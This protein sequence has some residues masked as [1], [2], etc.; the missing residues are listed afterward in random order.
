MTPWHCGSNWRCGQMKDDRGVVNFPSGAPVRNNGN[1][2]GGDGTNE[3]LARLEER[4]NHLAT[5]SQL[6]ELHFATHSKMQEMNINL[7]KLR[8][9]VNILKW[10][11]GLIVLGVLSAVIRLYA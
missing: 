7:E 3:R 11:G 9:E 5:H 8:A 2:G 4:V 6:Q 10:M 1:G